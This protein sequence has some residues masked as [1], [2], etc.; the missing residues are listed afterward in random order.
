M[1][2]KPDCKKTSEY[3]KFPCLRKCV[4]LDG[5]IRNTIYKRCAI[6]DY[7]YSNTF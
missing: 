3:N 4:S 1:S 6:I 7:S 5:E 2:L